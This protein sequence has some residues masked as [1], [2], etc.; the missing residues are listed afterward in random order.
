M[1]VFDSLRDNMFGVVTNTMGY[2]AVYTPSNS[3]TQQTA[4]VLFKDATTDEGIDERNIHFNY[5]NPVIEY[6]L[7]AFETLKDLVDENSGNSDA[8]EVIT[9]TFKDGDKQYYVQDVVTLFD[10]RTC[11]AILIKKN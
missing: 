6:L 7:P 10:G 1:N 11:K 8:K 4:K 3:D 9:I 5:A 2:T